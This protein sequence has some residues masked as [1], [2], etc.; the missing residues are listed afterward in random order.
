LLI[1]TI[2]TAGYLAATSPAANKAMPP[3]GSNILVMPLLGIMLRTTTSATR[4]AVQLPPPVPTPPNNFGFSANE[5][6]WMNAAQQAQQ[7]DDMKATGVGWVRIDMQWYVVQPSNTPTYN[8]SVYD[9]AIDA[10]NQRGL[11]ALV[12]LDYA[13]AW[14]A[15][16]GC[17]PTSSHQCAPADTA[18]F[19]AYAAAAAARYTPRGVTSWEIWNEPNARRFWYPGTDA[20]AYANLLRATYPVIKQL[21]PSAIVITAGLASTATEG[22]VAPPDYIASLYQAG[23]KPYF[24]AIGAHPYSYPLLPMINAEW[25][26]WTQM[27]EIHGVAASQGD[28]TKQIWMTEVGAPS[29]GPHHVS[30]SFQ[31]QIAE[32]AISLRNSYSWAGPLFWYDY[33]DLGTNPFVAADFFGLVRADGSQKPAYASF[34]QAIKQAL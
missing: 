30:E 4:A 10:I 1:I 9:R 21:N 6:I 15:I 23:A 33:Q 24:D 11:K 26:G 17:K 22:T 14:A 31:A 19:A 8:W 16:D 29:D 2:M 32:E 5:I 27:L 3:V 25:S 12:I 18:A 28:A 13:P 20:T 7:L 34:V